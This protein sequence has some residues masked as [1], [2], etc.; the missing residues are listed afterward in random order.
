MITFHI[1]D[2]V[3]AFEAEIR[4]TL[5]LWAINQSHE[6]AFSPFRE[7]S[8]VVG[9]Q[10]E[11][12]LRLGLRFP[13]P[14]E[15]A[16]RSPYV[17]MDGTASDRFDHLTDPLASAFQMVNALQEYDAPEYDELNRYQF[18]TSYQKR[19]NNV[20][21]NLVQ[22]C[23]ESIS[24]KLKLPLKSTPT[25]FFLSHDIDIVYGAILEDGN[26]VIRK[27]RFDLFFKMLFNLAIA[28]PEWL[29]MDKIMALE[30]EYDCKS[31]F[32]WIV[33]KGRINSREENADYTFHSRPIQRHFDAVARQGFEN[34][35]HKSISSES[36]R[37]ELTKFGN[38]AYANRYHFLKFRLP[39]AWHDVES[40]GLK[41]DASLGFS[42]E[43]GFR[44]SYGLPFNP[45]DFKERR[46][47]S[48]VEAPLNVMDRT[49]FQYKKQTAAEAR[50]DIFD[51]FERNRNNCV[52]SVLWHNNF[53]TDH[54]FKGYVALYKDILAYISDNKFRTISA[55]EITQHY[56]ISP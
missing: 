53:F 33:N 29:N 30:S 56:T 2:S 40:G 4:Y 39:D 43:M 13:T 11:A 26:N 38:A 9:T 46:P 27:G 12:H 34:G 44:N 49:F 22:K 5:G 35:L 3:R 7:N 31:I 17:Q 36:F 14:G 16:T 28:R 48:F 10:S 32:F 37:E 8:I 50:V 6:I 45:Y 1:N 15:P 41:L 47:F 25:R 51:F 55:R 18:K 19:L 21:D 42:A 20:Y 24:S 23:F 54:K 52:L